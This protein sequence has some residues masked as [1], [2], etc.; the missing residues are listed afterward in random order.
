VIPAVQQHLADALGAA[1]WRATRGADGLLATATAP[2]RPAPQP[3][4]TR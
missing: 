3:A 4:P 1:S 2:P